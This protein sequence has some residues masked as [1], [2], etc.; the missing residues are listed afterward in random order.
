MFCAFPDSF[1]LNNFYINCIAFI[2][3]NKLFYIV[4]KSYFQ[5][6]VLSNPPFKVSKVILA[7]CT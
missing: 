1:F 4:M 5:K 3:C 2:I 6:C 7:I